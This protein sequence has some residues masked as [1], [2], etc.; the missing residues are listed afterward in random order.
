MYKPAIGLEIHTQLNT[1]SKMFCGC[2]NSF[3]AKEANTY[4]CPVC[5]GHP[6]TLP[7]ANEEAIKKVLK[8]GLALNCEL[9]NISRFDR[10][11]YF[12]PDLPKGYQISQ[13]DQPLCFNGHLNIQ[14]KE[15]HI[16]R[17]HI[18]EDTGRLAHSKE[19]H[20]LVDFN[21]SGVPLMELVTGPDIASAKEAR[22]FAEELRLI[23][24]YIEVSEA[25]MEEG[26]M[27]V[28]VNISISKEGEEIGT[29]V[30]IKN[31]NSFR[32]VERAINY[33]VERQREIL[34]RGD[35][36]VQETRGFDEDKQ[37]TFSQ[38]EKEDVH[39]YRYFPEPDIP[40][41]YLNEPPFEKKKIS[42]G[43]ELPQ[44]KRKRFYEEYLLGEKE[45]EIMVSDKDLANYFEQSVSEAVN[46]IKESAT[47]KSVSEDEKRKI[48]RIASNY[49]ISDILGLLEGKPIR[50]IL[51]TPE[52]FGEF[53]NLIYSEKI[54]SKIAK[55]IL[56][57]MLASGKDPTHVID[58]KGLS[59]MDDDEEIR[60]IVQE[61]IESNSK[62]VDDYK[63]GKE[64][65]IQ[66]LIGQVMAKT[67]G[68]VLPE[69]AEEA[70]KK[71][72]SGK[73][74]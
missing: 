62:A 64:E 52:N 29:R 53:A 54:S 34:E 42:V 30:E 58:D 71:I 60:G 12:Y 28:E 19:G 16:K 40:P 44:A 70:L 11:N 32:S 20:S 43:I 24:R 63:K 69:K 31:L 51:I 13:N 39:D 35:S 57:E 17:V 25:N 45:I 8:T 2:K 74:K 46:W 14:G 67:K 49:L 38:R 48:A 4:V 65:A 5:L 47:Q 72:L 3:Y 37:K 73:K 18:E 61:V 59:Q 22:Q 33:E 15:I 66:F 56:K 21:R 6:G 23:L 26:Q 36:V 50:D 27:R 7:V 1:K 55:S 9:A 68:R 41:L 10:K